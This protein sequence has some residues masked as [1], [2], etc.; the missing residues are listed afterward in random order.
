LGVADSEKKLI[1]NEISKEFSKIIEKNE[2]LDTFL[3]KKK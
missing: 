3:K 2:D 1:K